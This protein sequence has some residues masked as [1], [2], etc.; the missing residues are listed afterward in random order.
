L[1]DTDHVWKLTEWAF[2]RPG[3]GK[4]VRVERCSLHW[5]EN[6]PWLD[7][8]RYHQRMVTVGFELPTSTTIKEERDIHREMGDSPA[9]QHS[10]DWLK[11]RHD[12]QR[13]RRRIKQLSAQDTTSIVTEG[14][15]RWLC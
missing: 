11:A 7:D 1:T 6:I 4:H 8:E 14:P 15:Y 12:Y 2:P 5:R 13:S 10:V 3:T 9:R